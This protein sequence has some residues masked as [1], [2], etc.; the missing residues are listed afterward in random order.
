MKDVAPE[1]ALL[2]GGSFDPPHEG[3]MNL[4]RS[5]LQAV[6]PDSVIVIPSAAPPHKRAGNT[7]W[8]LR[9]AMCECFRPLFEHLVVSD[10]EERRGGKSYTFD[11]VQALRAERCESVFY[12]CVG[13]DM[14]RSF[15]TWYRWQELLALVVLVALARTPGEE[16][17]LRQAACVLAQA[18]GQVVFATAG[19]VPVSSTAIR[20]AVRAG[21][22]NAL[23]QVPPPADAIV[24][25]EGLYRA[26]LE[27]GAV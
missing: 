17:E 22:P 20:A 24:R 26:G 8:P 25:A 3:H 12:L 2:F 6:R 19:V 9:A 11:T 23:A 1:K 5:A 15:T 21:I 7:P 16:E 10:I 4:L 27:S 18:G 13:G 14:L